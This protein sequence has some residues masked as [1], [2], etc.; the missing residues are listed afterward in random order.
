MGI[1]DT[2]KMRVNPERLSGYVS[3]DIHAQSVPVS[4]HRAL[5][6]SGERLKLSNSD[7]ALRL[8]N[9]AYKEWQEE[10]WAYYDAI[11]EIKY[12][13]GMLASVLSRIRLYAA[14]NVDPDAVPVSTL[15]YRRRLAEQSKEEQQE[16]VET[17]MTVPPAITKEVMAYMEELVSDLFTGHG[18]SSGFLRTFALNM[19]VPGECY[20]IKIKDKWFIKSTSEIDVDASGQIFLRPQRT[21]SGTSGTAGGLDGTKK[22]PKHTLVYRIWKEHPRYSEEPESSM[23]GLREVCEELI[24]LQQM[25]RTSARSRLHGGILF[26]PDDLVAAGSSIAEDIADEEEKLDELTGALYDN[27]TAPITDER[28][29]SSVVPTI[30]TGPAESGQHL[31]H[32]QMERKVDQHL[33]ERADRAL[34]RILQGL[35]MP[36]DFVTGLA[37]VR[38]TNAKNIDESL[39]KSHIEPLALMLCDALRITYFIPHIKS[40]FPTLNKKELDMLTLWYDPSEI[41]TKADPAESADKGFDAMVLSADAW[42]QAHGFSDADAPTE[43]ELALRAF[44]GST[45]PPETV[46]VLFNHVFPTVLAA[47]RKANLEKSSVP[48]DE[49]AQELLYGEVQVPSSQTV[50]NGSEPT[51]YED[52]A[53]TASTV[54]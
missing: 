4:A 12:G 27:M 22:L 41:V 10:A 26:V 43:E 7:D 18:G 5:T 2:M 23:M 36:K 16:D 50:R 45:I 33:V 54:S 39:Y 21:S 53:R 15:N 17:E 47:Q 37:N 44:L 30:L 20:L 8:R 28:S 49:T 42:R 51:S 38:Y 48:M 25:I 19:S 46:G 31:H 3:T 9:R 29:A 13:F 1:I 34:E 32:I 6:A 52:I 11:G 14:L 24:S 35:D 40:K